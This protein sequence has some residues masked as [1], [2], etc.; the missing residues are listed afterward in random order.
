MNEESKGRIQIGNGLDERRNVFKEPRP[1][2]ELPEEVRRYISDRKRITGSKETSVQ[3]LEG[4][5]ML[6]LILY[7]HTM[8]PVLKSDIYNNVARSESVQRKIDKL[9]EM[10]LIEI[11]ATGKTNSN[12]I[13]MTEKGHRVAEVMSEMIRL[14]DEDDE[15]RSS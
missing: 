4:K 12:V 1:Y 13:V 14:I 15:D 3:M 6:T 8:S 11:Y 7:L 10:G 2:E 9:D 5:H